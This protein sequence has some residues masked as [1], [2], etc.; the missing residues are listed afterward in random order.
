MILALCSSCKKKVWIEKHIPPSSSQVK[1]YYEP[2]ND[3]LTRA[4][5][6][7]S[8]IEFESFRKNL[9]LNKPVT[10]ADIEQKMGWQLD[11]SLPWWS[12]PRAF[13]VGYMSYSEGRRVISVKKGK[14]VYFEE[15]NW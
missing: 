1:I 7:C 14:R 13:D 4:V 15:I 8:T 6:E 5:F 3:A 11:N 9:G 2:G 12:P 10:F